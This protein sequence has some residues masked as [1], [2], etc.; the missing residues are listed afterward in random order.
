MELLN[1]DYSDMQQGS[2]LLHKQLGIDEMD[3]QKQREQSLRNRVHE[4]FIAGR[5]DALDDLRIGLGLGGKLVVTEYVVRICIIGAVHSLFLYII[6]GISTYYRTGIVNWNICFGPFPTETVTQLAFGPQEI[7]RDMVFDQQ[8]RFRFIKFIRYKDD[9]SAC[10]GENDPRLRTQQLFETE[11]EQ[12]F[13]NKMEDDPRFIRRFLSLCT[14]S[15][16]LPDIDTHPEYK[17]LVEF[18]DS[19]MDD[20]FLPVIHTCD[21]VMKLP[22]TAYNANMEKFEKKLDVTMRHV[23]GKFDME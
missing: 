19:E 16:F 9:P 15:A 20:E 23:E 18:N 2:I 4:L 21:K 8:G 1:I 6:Y 22:A 12:W 5:S 7:T 13:G 14:G 3:D 10:E 11:M 17:I